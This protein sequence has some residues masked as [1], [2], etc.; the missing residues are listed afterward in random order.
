MFLRL[1][2]C[3]D[4]QKAHKASGKIFATG[5]VLRYAPLYL[6][7]KSISF[8][9]Q[10]CFIPLIYNNIRDIA[11]DEANFGKIISIDAS[12]NITPEHG[13]YIMR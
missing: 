12:E 3:E 2:Q 9:T 7:R 8:D 10:F 13:G 6:Y 5:F 11:R 4:I 1:E